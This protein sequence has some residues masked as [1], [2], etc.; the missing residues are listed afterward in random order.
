MP[1][2]PIGVGNFKRHK[3]KHTTTILSMPADPIGVGNETIRDVVIIG[4]AFQCLLTP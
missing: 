2:D 1:A 3:W 4:I